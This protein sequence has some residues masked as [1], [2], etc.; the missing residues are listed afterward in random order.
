MY[1]KGRK[2]SACSG[3]IVGCVKGDESLVPRDFVIYFS[4]SDFRRRQLPVTANHH[5]HPP[6]PKFLP[7]PPE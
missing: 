4:P 6:P 1:D 7:I 3:S 2:T 5:P